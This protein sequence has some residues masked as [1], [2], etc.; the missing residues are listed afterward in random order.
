[1]PA[2]AALSRVCPVCPWGFQQETSPGKRKGI[3]TPW[4]SVTQ[5]SLGSFPGLTAWLRL[6]APCPMRAI[7]APRVLQSRVPACAWGGTRALSLP[8]V[9][10]QVWSWILGSTPWGCSR[11]P[12]ELAQPAEQGRS[13]TCRMQCRGAWHRAGALHGPRAVLASQ[14]SPGLLALSQPFLTREKT[15]QACAECRDCRLCSSQDREHGVGG[16]AG[17]V[18][19]AMQKMPQCSGSHLQSCTGCRSLL[20]PPV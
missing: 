4:F 1:M 18:L 9:E 14:L 15:E 3:S 12:G 2:L 16:R 13:F 7:K 8:A 11:S 17:G 6:A 19:E 20:L 10:G 5:G